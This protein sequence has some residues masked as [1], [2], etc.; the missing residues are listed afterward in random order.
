MFIHQ[1]D[2]LP[3]RKSK[4]TQSY[5]LSRRINVS[6]DLS[7]FIKK[8]LIIPLHHKCD[9]VTT[10]IFLLSFCLSEKEGV[11]SAAMHS[12]QVVILKA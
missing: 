8:N 9:H 3:P 12:G 7:V 6:E 10:F 11:Q 4:L 5:K 2:V 1:A